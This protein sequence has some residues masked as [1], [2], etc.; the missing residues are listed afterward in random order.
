M[1]CF[2]LSFRFKTRFL[3]GFTLL[4][5]VVCVAALA[6][7]RPKAPA[8]GS[9]VRIG[10]GDL[11]DISVFDTPELSGSFRLNN[12]GMV[13]LPLLGAVPLQG[14]TPEQAQQ[15]LTQR[16]TDSGLLKAPHVTVAVTEYGAQAITV[17]GE[18][19]KPGSYP[20]LG[21]PR[22]LEFI[23]L[24]EGL[25]PTAAK[26]ALVTHRTDPAHPVTV[27]LADTA[28]QSA[29][30]IPLQP[31]DV[32]L[33]PKAGIVYVIGDVAKPGGFL[34][35]SDSISVLQA[36]ALAAGPNGTAKLNDSRIIRKTPAGVSD[37]AVPL[38]RVLKSKSSDLKLQAGDVLFVPSSAAKTAGKSA[39][40][41]VLQTIAGVALYGAVLR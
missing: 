19:K 4:M 38:A 6:Q 5:L 30:N 40:Q 13:L 14:L 33:V 2:L 34:M 20:P 25:T 10:P 28:D 17:L 9:V 3:V 23:S 32:V 16:L 11:L 18:V 15:L 1:L 27:N 26:T 22:L 41:A 7:E 8:T 24:A 39:A 21:T 35:D 12:Q 37:I 29:A 36:L 31:G